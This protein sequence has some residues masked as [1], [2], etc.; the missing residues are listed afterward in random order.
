MWKHFLKLMMVTLLSLSPS[1]VL[2]TVMKVDLLNVEP[3]DT[4]CDV[5]E[6]P[7]PCRPRDELPIYVPPV[8]VD[9]NDMSRGFGDGDLNRCTNVV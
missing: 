7:V 2:P 1:L 4:D 6:P 9:C 8:D 3:S 5:A